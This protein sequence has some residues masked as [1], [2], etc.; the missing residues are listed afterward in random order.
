M[1]QYHTAGS[2]ARI[3]TPSL[4]N[5]KTTLSPSPHMVSLK[6]RSVF[7]PCR[8][9]PPSTISS[10]KLGPCFPPPLTATAR[11]AQG[12]LNPRAI[13]TVLA[14]WRPP[15]ILA[16]ARGS[17]FPHCCN[18]GHRVPRA[19][20][21]NLIYHM[22]CVFVHI[23]ISLPLIIHLANFKGALHSQLDVLGFIT[24]ISCISLVG[25]ANDALL[26]HSQ[27]WQRGSLLL[28]GRLWRAFCPGQAP[29]DFLLCIQIRGTQCQRGL[30]T[31]IQ[32]GQ[33]KQDLRA[34]DNGA[35]TENQ[36]VFAHHFKLPSLIR[37]VPWLETQA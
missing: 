5:A 36:H 11:E 9:P 32:S 30:L 33:W 20:L 4:C 25:L 19:R 6:G 37:V 7:Q 23:N 16:C 18:D 13:C 12:A 3:L 27:A 26:K 17:G 8:L 34:S 22:A 29:P 10:C 2:K 1:T 21:A 24:F 35:N 14:G 15:R 28:Q 31:D